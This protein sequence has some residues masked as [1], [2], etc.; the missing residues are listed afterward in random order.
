M[1]D[2]N[3][4]MLNKLDRGALKK[5]S[6]D[7]LCEI[8]LILLERDR[9]LTRRVEE[10]ERRLNQN[11][12]NS[13]KPPSS[14]MP[15][16]PRAPKEPPS[17]KKPGGQAGHKANFRAP[18]SKKRVD[19]I[20]DVMPDRCSHCDA[21][22]KGRDKHPRRHQVVE[23]PPILLR[24]TE[25]LLHALR[26]RNCG[27]VTRAA[28]PEGVSSRLMGPRL[29]ALTAMWGGCFRLSKREVQAMLKAQFELDVS[30]GAVSGCEKAMTV[31]LAP[32]MGEAL[33]YAQTQPI[34]NMDETGWKE[35]RKLAWLWTLVTPFVTVFKVQAGRSASAM[36]EL[37]GVFAGVLG[38]D[39]YGAPA[40]RAYRRAAGTLGPQAR[41]T[42]CG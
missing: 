37:L 20:K 39:R 35:R 29:T 26:C 18:F 38:S 7:Q 3:Q 15:G 42:P 32:A 8:V 34:G 11:S 16:T 4:E 10:L 22:L 33:D 17:G 1:D 23:L 2:A 40:R 9:K 24:V 36:K 25:Y 21:G 12:N 28:V 6:H 5:L 13:S 31:A 19:E 41:T 14:D 27:H 30:L